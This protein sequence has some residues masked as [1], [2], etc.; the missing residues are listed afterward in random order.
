MKRAM[1]L[2]DGRLIELEVS[3]PEQIDSSPLASLWVRHRSYWLDGVPI[4]QAEG[5]R[6]ISMAGGNHGEAASATA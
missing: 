2:P 5:D 6:I 3:E 4:S 1:T